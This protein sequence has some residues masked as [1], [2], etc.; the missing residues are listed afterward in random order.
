LTERLY[1]QDTYRTEFEAR[2]V[3]VEPRA[4]GYAVELDRTC[5]Y[6]EAG[7]QPADAGEIEG[8][9]IEAVVEEADRVLHLISRRPDFGP[10]DK[11]SGSID[12]NRRLINMQQHTGQHVLSQSFLRQLG[13]AT[14][15]SKLGVEHSTIDIDAP[16]LTWE[17][18]KAAEDLANRIVYENRPVEIFEAGKHE[19]EG[20]RIK[21][22]IDRDLI[23]VVEVK[24]FDKSPC[25]GTHTGTTGE[26]GPIKILRWEKVRDATRVEFIC[27]MLAMDDYF[28]KSR[29][30]VELAQDLTTKDRGLPDLI[31][32]LLEE[33]K[34]LSK[35]VDG[36]RLELARYRAGSLLESARDIGGVRVVS[37]YMEEGTPAEIREMA[38]RITE[39]PAA[40]ALLACGK[41]TLHFV[42]SRSGDVGVDMREALKA[43]CREVEGKG[44]GK[45]EVCQGGGKNPHKAPDALKEAE[46]VVEELLAGSSSPE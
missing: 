39:D 13:A 10:G 45:P 24:D 5:F 22:P 28:W 30:L 32:Q 36:L 29:F 6:P 14:V 17:Q 23:R 25:G 27:G 44:G 3:A 21:M 4:G 38:A 33:R 16:A 9:G 42:F 31:P 40:I 8:I 12:W 11:V 18:A 43:A 2:V 41:E 35:Q 20:L 19:V 15:S 46:K 26:V 34:H 1:Q 7:G 37:S